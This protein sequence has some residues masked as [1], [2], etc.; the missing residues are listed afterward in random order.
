MMFI[1]LGWLLLST[2]STAVQATD[3][4]N[5]VMAEGGSLLDSY[6]IKHESLEFNKK[7]G[8]GRHVRRRVRQRLC[9]ACSHDSR[10]HAQF[11]RGVEGQAPHR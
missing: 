1:M 2:Q 11:R 3:L 7:I 10:S 6:A 4:V 5:K 9:G 8:E